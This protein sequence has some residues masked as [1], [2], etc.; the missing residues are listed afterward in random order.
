M[1]ILITIFEDNSV[2]RPILTLL[3]KVTKPQGLTVKG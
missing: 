2:I 3:H 1:K